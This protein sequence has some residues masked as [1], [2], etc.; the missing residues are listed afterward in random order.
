MIRAESEKLSFN[1]GKVLIMDELN[2]KQPKDIRKFKVE[3]LDG[4]LLS[5]EI[6]FII[7]W[8]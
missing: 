8:Y 4:T 1:D 6:G 5:N 7:A 2:Y 3:L